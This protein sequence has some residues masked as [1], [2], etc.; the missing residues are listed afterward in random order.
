MDRGIERCVVWGSG[1]R[2]GGGDGGERPET[3]GIVDLIEEYDDFPL[4]LL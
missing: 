2:D 3:T 4:Y 1:V